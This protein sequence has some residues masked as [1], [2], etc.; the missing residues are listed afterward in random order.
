VYFDADNATPELGA[1]FPSTALFPTILILV[2]YSVVA[3]SLN[4]TATDVG[5]VTVEVVVAAFVV[6][7][8]LPEM[9]RA[10]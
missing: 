1:Q 7:L 6:V 5:H 2:P 8:P 4:V 3:N 10:R 9:S